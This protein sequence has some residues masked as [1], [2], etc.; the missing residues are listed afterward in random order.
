MS[1]WPIRVQLTLRYF[2][3]FSAAALLLVLCSWLSLRTS[4]V[5]T[6]QSE[7]DERIE[8]LAGFLARQS[9]NANLE[10]IRTALNREYAGRDEG[11]HLLIID[12]NGEWLYYSDRRSVSLPLPPLPR[13]S[14]SSTIALQ[15]T[16]PLQSLSRTIKVNDETYTVVTGLSFHHADELLVSFARKSS[17]AH[18]SALDYGCDRRP[19]GEPQSLGAGRRDQR[20]GP[21][22]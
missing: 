21:A 12:Q 8:D 14:R 4:L 1:H 3:F 9:Q 13:R 17:A 15:R 22:H 11:K 20:R 19:P 5:S 18:A 6:A 7:L 10:Q 16:Q 2:I